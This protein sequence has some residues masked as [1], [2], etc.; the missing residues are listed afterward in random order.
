MIWLEFSPLAR[1]VEKVC[2]C[3]VK[4]FSVAKEAVESFA[5]QKAYL[6]G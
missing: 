5:K 1:G 3:V 6:S 4:I 2:C